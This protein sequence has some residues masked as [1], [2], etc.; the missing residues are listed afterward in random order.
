MEKKKIR[1]PLIRKKRV[2]NKPQPTKEQQVRGSF[3]SDRVINDFSVGS[4]KC[5]LYF[6]EPSLTYDEF[7]AIKDICISGDSVTLKWSKQ[8]TLHICAIPNV[9][10]SFTFAIDDTGQDCEVLKVLFLFFYH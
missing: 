1:M 6:P 2:K 7:G 4:C 9:P 10:P 8:C 5:E 3:F